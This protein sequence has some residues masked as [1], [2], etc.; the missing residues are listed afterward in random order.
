MQNTFRI[1]DFNN[2]FPKLTA[3]LIRN[4]PGITCFNR[5]TLCCVTYNK[6]DPLEFGILLETYKERDRQYYSI[7]TG[8]TGK[9]GEKLYYEVYPELYNREQAKIVA[10]VLKM[11]KWADEKID[12]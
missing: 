8:K 11:I 3:P 6:E 9:K 4:H 2:K 5:K 10:S 12:N 1:Q 7:A